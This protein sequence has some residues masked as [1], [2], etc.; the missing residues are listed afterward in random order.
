MNCCRHIWAATWENQQS[1]Y[2]KTKTQISFAVT[3]KLISTF[4]F[5]TWIVQYLYF[6][7]TK[8]LAFSHLQWLYS[9]VCVRGP[10]QNPHCWF[11][12]VAAHMF[13]YLPWKFPVLLCVTFEWRCFYDV[14][15][16]NWTCLM[17]INAF[18]FAHARGKT[19]DG[20]S[21]QYFIFYLFCFVAIFDLVHDV[22]SIHSL[23]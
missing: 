19:Q 3:V 8:F 6:I 21:G 5:A 12:H 14:K 17:R 2:A 13:S 9:L 1:A 7:N 20:W 15:Q 10:G 4:V 16:V 23:C 22:A 11:S 18:F